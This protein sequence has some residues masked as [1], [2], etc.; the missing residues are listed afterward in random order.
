MKKEEETKFPKEI[1]KYIDKLFPKGDKRRG[2]AMV[3][4]A[5]S[6]ICGKEKGENENK[7]MVSSNTNNN[8]DSNCYLTL[9]YI[10]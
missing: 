1:V 6:Y 2:E 9:F 3:L 5:I 7:W 10:K 8:I 4:S